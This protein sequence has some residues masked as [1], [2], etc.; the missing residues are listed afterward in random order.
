MITHSTLYKNIKQVFHIYSIKVKKRNK[1]IKYLN[2]N[3]IDAKIHYPIPMHL[4]PAAK[5]Y[6]YKIGDFPIT[7]KICKNV[8]SL[9]VHEYISN[10]QQQYIVN[11]IKRFYKI[12]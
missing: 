6:N 5:K 1:L 2:Q 10:K 4:Q 8:I 9:P 12:I 11:K 7:E 3:G